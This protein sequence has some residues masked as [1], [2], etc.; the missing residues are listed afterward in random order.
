MRT[1]FYVETERDNKKLWEGL[2]LF[3]ETH[4]DIRTDVKCLAGIYCKG[5]REESKA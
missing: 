3:R 2:S 4:W 5:K 1:C